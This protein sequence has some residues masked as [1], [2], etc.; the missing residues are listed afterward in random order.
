MKHLLKT[1]IGQMRILGFLEG[2][3]LLILVFLAVPM[4][5]LFDNP[6]VSKTVGPIHGAIF[7]IFLISTFRVGAEQA[8]KFK[9]TTWKIVLACFIPFGT[10]Y[11]DHT[12]LRSIKDK[13]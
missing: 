1:K 2:V 7:I 3:T 8:W 13:A 4:K 10:F 5:Y 9:E 6:V 11:I 12:L